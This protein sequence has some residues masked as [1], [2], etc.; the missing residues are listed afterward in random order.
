[1]IYVLTFDKGWFYQFIVRADTGYRRQVDL[2]GQ[3]LLAAVSF[4]R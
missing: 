1:M 3:D 2:A 4:L